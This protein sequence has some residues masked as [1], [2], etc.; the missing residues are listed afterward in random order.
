MHEQQ[1]AMRL[2]LAVKA[3]QGE[4]LLQSEREA[5]AEALQLLRRRRLKAEAQASLR[6]LLHPTKETIN[7]YP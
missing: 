2:R 7:R 6:A 1:E 3:A 4:T 5:L